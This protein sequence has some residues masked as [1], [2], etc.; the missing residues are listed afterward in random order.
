MEGTIVQCFWLPVHA[1]VPSA[2]ESAPT[3]A[4][5]LN[6]SRATNPRHNPPEDTLNRLLRPSK[7]ALSSRELSVPP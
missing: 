6:V 4:C 1:V 2:R 7:L 3:A 5:S